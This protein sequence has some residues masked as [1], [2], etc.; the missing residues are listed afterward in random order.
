MSMIWYAG[1]PADYGADNVTVSARNA[2]DTGTVT[3]E[4]LVQ[5]AAT[6]LSIYLTRST[7]GTLLDSD[8]LQDATGTPV[9]TIT[10]AI[11][12]AIWFQADDAVTGNKSV[13]GT[14]DNGTTW[15]MFHP[16]QG[17]TIDRLVVA[18]AGVTL[19]S[20]GGHTDVTITGSEAD[21][22]VLT[23]NSGTGVASFQ[24]GGGGSGLP[25]GGTTD[26]VLV[27]Q[28]ATDGDADWETQ[29]TVPAG[30]ADGALLAK[31]SA[32]DG[33]TEWI[34]G[35]TYWKAWS[36]TQSAYDALGSYDSGTLYVIT[37]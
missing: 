6:E 2:A 30:G 14:P 3:V 19:G 16:D 7:G 4:N 35:T 36:G 9:D 12:E 33:A 22:S 18:E 23:W 13:F 24:P 17:P 25:S 20:I 34:A 37:D 31:S 11:A 15:Y 32:S 27:K 1:T 28:S 26:Q 5:Y 8:S 21:N 10:G 29:Y